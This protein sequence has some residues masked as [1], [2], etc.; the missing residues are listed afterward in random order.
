MQHPPS[1]QNSLLRK[2]L[3]QLINKGNYCLVYACNYSSVGVAV[4]N[5]TFTLNNANG[6][7][8]MDGGNLSRSTE[9]QADNTTNAILFVTITGP[10][11]SVRINSI[12][13]Q[14]GLVYADLYVMQLPSPTN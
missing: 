5:Y 7:L 2:F 4:A 13:D 12:G 1:L 11:A 6:L 14:T 9:Y 3:L 10:N 8:L